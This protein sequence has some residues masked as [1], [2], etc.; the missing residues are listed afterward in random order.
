MSRGAHSRVDDHYDP[1]RGGTTDRYDTKEP[2]HPYNL[3]GSLD[4]YD[5]RYDPSYDPNQEDPKDSSQFHD[6]DWDDH[7]KSSRGAQR[8]RHDHH[9]TG[10]G[11]RGE[12]RH[13]HL[14]GRRF[15]RQMM[16]E[17]R[18]SVQEAVGADR[19]ARQARPCPRLEVR[20]PQPRSQVPSRERKAVLIE[21]RRLNPP[22]FNGEYDPLLAEEWLEYINQYLD[23]L[24]IEDGGLRVFLAV[25]QLTYDARHWWKLVGHS[26]GDTWEEFEK[27]FQNQY[28]PNSVVNRLRRQFE[29]LTQGDK[30]VDKYAQEFYSLSRYAPDL[31]ADEDLRCR[32]FEEGLRPSIKDRVMSQLYSDFVTLVES[33]RATELSWELIQK[34]KEDRMFHEASSSKG[35]RQSRKRKSSSPESSPEVLKRS[36]NVGSSFTGVRHSTSQRSLVCH[37]CDRPGHAMSQCP[38]LAQARASVSWTRPQ[39]P[40]TG[41]FKPFGQGPIVC[42]GCHQPGHFIRDCPNRPAGS[43]A[44]STD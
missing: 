7:P 3:E 30:S 33:A 8:E 34:E 39:Q 22:T 27:A 16:E 11:D 36:T 19:P 28:L 31:I 9:G 32:R 29:E 35:D 13:R 38:S 37:L 42:Y 15:F 12:R 26:V 44:T 6:D 43:R 41:G 17:N 24:G 25:F 4:R 10:R 23:T 20:L 21:F 18:E 2:L 1:R 40:R 14:F 5:S